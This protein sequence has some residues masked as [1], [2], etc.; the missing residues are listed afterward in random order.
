MKTLLLIVGLF[1]ASNLSAQADTCS[2]LVKVPYEKITSIVSD[3]NHFT[4]GALSLKNAYE[5]QMFIWRDSISKIVMTVK[6]YTDNAGVKTIGTIKISPYTQSP[7][8]TNKL[9][10]DIFTKS[11]SAMFKG[12]PVTFQ[13][14]VAILSKANSAELRNNSI[15][16]Y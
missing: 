15:T 13:S 12:C 1:A 4:N 16:I 7:P 10:A 9:I 5:D 8:E 11:I 14:N 2:N 6:T 3:L